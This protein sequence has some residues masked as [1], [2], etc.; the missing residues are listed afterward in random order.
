MRATDSSF[1][2]V[3]TTIF[4][5][6]GINFWIYLIACVLS[7]PKQAAIVIIGSLMLEEANGKKDLYVF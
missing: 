5:T 3:I 2:Q 6:C 1:S 7:L 4:A